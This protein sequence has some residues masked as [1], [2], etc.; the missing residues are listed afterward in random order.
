[1]IKAALNRFYN[2]AEQRARGEGYPGGKMVGPPSAQEAGWDVSIRVPQMPP[3]I[4]PR[5]QDLVNPTK[6]PSPQPAEPIIPII[7]TRG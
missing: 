2:H 6:V 5:L 4:P 3:A 1:M 7:G